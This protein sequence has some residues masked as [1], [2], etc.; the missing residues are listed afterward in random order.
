L[1]DFDSNLKIK[2][3][4]NSLKELMKTNNFKN[5]QMLLV[6]NKSNLYTKKTNLSKDT[7]TSKKNQILDL[8]KTQNLNV[9]HVETTL[10][11]LIH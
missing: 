4:E 9:H 2:E 7:K 11:T 1:G 6:F 5:I 3:I 10:K 8:I